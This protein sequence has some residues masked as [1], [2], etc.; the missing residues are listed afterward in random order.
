MARQVACKACGKTFAPHGRMPRSHCKRCSAK[1]DRAAAKAITAKCRVC[2]TQFTARTRTACY[3]SAECRARG[4]REYIRK[5]MRRYIGDPEKRALKLARARVAS[6]SRRA[7]KKGGGTEQPQPKG[8]PAGRDAMSLPDNATGPKTAACGLCGRTFAPYGGAT[9]VNCKQCRAK[10]DAEINRVF[11]VNCKACGKRFTTANRSVRYCSTECR[12]AGK[13][14]SDLKYD[15]MRST[16]PEKHAM[17]LAHMRAR[18]DRR[19][20]G[21]KG[22]QRP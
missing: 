9:H 16:D 15:H 21:G 20:A 7:G 2:G 14:R 1:A 6:A 4:N 10:M 18:A 3:C 22:A 12:A 13:R 17:R 19:R 11:D 8:T 5:Y